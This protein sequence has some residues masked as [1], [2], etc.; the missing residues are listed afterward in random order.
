MKYFNKIISIGLLLSF[1]VIFLVPI[2][3]LNIHKISSIIFLLLSLI[4]TLI[5]VKKINIKKII[6]IIIIL[7]SFMSG[8][9]SMFYDIWII[10]H[11]SIGIISIM[12]IAIHLFIYHKKIV[13]K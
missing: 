5:N 6:L 8:I 1:I 10:I 7:L 4:H 11:K 13:R 12:L 2:T 9:L 3:G